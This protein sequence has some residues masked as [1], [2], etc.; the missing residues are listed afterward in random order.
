[1]I[2]AIAIGGGLQNEATKRPAV[3]ESLCELGTNITYLE[4]CV[5]SLLER[6]RPIRSNGDATC[7]E[8]TSPV[9]CDVCILSG[10]IS[11]QARRVVNLAH[12]VRECTGS[13]EI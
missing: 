8:Q 6:L 11:D 10:A 13:L 7:K 4:E 1:M 2:M 9:P 12:R 3:E 5:L